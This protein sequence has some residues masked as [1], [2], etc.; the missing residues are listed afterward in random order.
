MRSRENLGRATEMLYI[1]KK[2]VAKQHNSTEFAAMVEVSFSTEN[3]H[4]QLR[5]KNG[6]AT[7]HDA[8]AGTSTDHVTEGYLQDLENASEGVDPVVTSALTAM[9]YISCKIIL[10]ESDWCFQTF[11]RSFSDRKSL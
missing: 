7:H 9:V 4:L 3:S 10:T 6:E 1:L 2:Y 5:H 11:V 8:V